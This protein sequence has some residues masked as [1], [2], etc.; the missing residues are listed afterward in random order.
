MRLNLFG[1]LMPR[2][3]AFVDLFY[4]QSRHAVAAA[5]ELR[6]LI[7]GEN[8]PEHHFEAIGRIEGEADAVAKQAGAPSSS[9][10]RRSNIDTVGLP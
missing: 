10:S 7:Y 3:E 9:A 5:M 8:T 1:F 4:E 6:A 2:E